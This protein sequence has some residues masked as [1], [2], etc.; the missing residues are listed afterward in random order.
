M[1]M[2]RV[3]PMLVLFLFLSGSQSFLMVDPA[4]PGCGNCWLWP[5]GWGC[6]AYGD[7]ELQSPTAKITLK[8][9]SYTVG[10]S[11]DVEQAFKDAN[12]THAYG[13]ILMTAYGKTKEKTREIEYPHFVVTAF[14][15]GDRDNHENKINAEKAVNMYND[16]FEHYFEKN[17]EQKKRS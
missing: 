2:Y 4:Y 16:I 17:K 7:I 14:V 12:I 11:Q 5:T 8:K 13:F 15:P 6:L 10:V 9:E 1:L 3:V